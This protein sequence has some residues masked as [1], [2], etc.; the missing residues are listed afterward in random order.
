MLA[1]VRADAILARNRRP[2]PTR[3]DV[4]RLGP[5][6]PLPTRV[7]LSVLHLR[8]LHSMAKFGAICLGSNGL[9]TRV[10]VGVFNPSFFL[11]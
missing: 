7:G 2:L 1:R 4:S 8:S 10:S 11:S 9:L 6:G 3:A 5:S